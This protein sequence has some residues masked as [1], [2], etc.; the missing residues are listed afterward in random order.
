MTI[1]VISTH[2]VSSGPQAASRGCAEWSVGG[3]KE[4]LPPMYGSK[5]S[6]RERLTLPQGLHRF[7][8]SGVRFM[9]ARKEMRIKRLMR[10]H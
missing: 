10:P 6:W 5:F 9:G 4:K 8:A 3:Q 7:M 2:S 1:L